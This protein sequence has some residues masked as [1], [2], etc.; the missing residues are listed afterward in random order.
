MTIRIPARIDT[1]LKGAAEA[2]TKRP[3]ALPVKGKLLRDVKQE[4]RA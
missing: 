3:V 2:L 4:R 1:Q